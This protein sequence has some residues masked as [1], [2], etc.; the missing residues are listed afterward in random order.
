M[1]YSRIM[2]FAVSAV[3]LASCR[4]QVPDPQLPDDS[5]SASATLV[6]DVPDKPIGDP[7]EAIY[8]PGFAIVKFSDETAQRIERSTEPAAL[9]AVCEELGV[10]SLERVF[11]YAGE[12]EARTRREGMHQFYMVEFDKGISLA[13]ARE[14]FEAL[15]DVETFECQPRAKMLDVNDPSFRSQWGLMGSCNVHVQEVWKYTTGD[16][17]VVVSI[18]DTGVALEHPDLE[19]NC[20]VNNRNFGKSGPNIAPGRHGTHVAGIVA[21]VTNNGVG[22]AGMAGGDY[23]NSK[24]GITLQSAQVF[25]DAGNAPSFASVIKWGADNGALISQNSWGY[26]Y[27]S[28]QDGKL[29]DSEKQ[30]ALAARISSTDKAAIDYF[31]KYAGCDG[32]GN[33]KPGSLMK[34][35]VVVFSA[36][37]D[38]ITNGLPSNYG[39]NISVGATTSSGQIASYS[40][41]GDWVDICAP[42]SS[43]YSTVPGNTYANL[44]GTSM[45][46]PCVSG[47]CALIVSA[48]GGEG[49]TNDDLEEILIAG[50]DPF[51][52]NYL[53]HNAGPYL[54][55]KNSFEYAFAKYKRD[56]N[57]APV[58]NIDY[59]G[60]FTFR[61]YQK[62][63]IPVEIVDP[64]GD[65]LTVNA[66]IEGRAGFTQDP[67]DPKIWHF[68]IVGEL[69]TDFKEKKVRI[70][71]YDAYGGSV[72]HEFSYIVL[73]NNAP[74]LMGQVDNFVMIGLSD[75]KTIDVSNL[76]SDP[77]GE[78]LNITAKVSPTNGAKVDLKDGK[79]VI[80]PGEYG[81]YEITLTATDALKARKLHMFWFLVK[82]KDTPIDM[83]P[84]PVKDY[85]YVRCGMEK[86]AVHMVM[87][88]A[89]GSVV[90]DTNVACSLFEPAKLD[91]RGF[92]P[93]AYSVTATRP[94]GSSLTSNIVKR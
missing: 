31:R 10:S 89:A 86:E 17:R 13:K 90:M 26:D 22:I 46:C 48:F 63:D 71:A 34:G 39:P 12:Y 15:P 47:A 36:G 27:D 20:G 8:L 57:E 79:L 29:S 94:D 93:G 23:Q 4:T 49:F 80:T 41:Y 40:N 30:R 62:V 21:A 14:V 91:M 33:Q 11:P 83:Y 53:G 9:K 37:N 76:F 16:P 54:N 45:A 50:A 28:D 43:I 73:K 19:W 78:E 38:G 5:S 60:D 66:D 81:P 69:V 51:A 56:H 18:V 82:E 1:K 6:A 67:N 65:P 61:Q 35:G 44:S 59:D 87:V 58:I 84:N 72:Y 24:R 85:L 92:A 68:T 32:N 70:E 52:I 3:L 25:D 88:N 55:M 42:G 74:E 2:L 75:K 64:D 7:E 77:D